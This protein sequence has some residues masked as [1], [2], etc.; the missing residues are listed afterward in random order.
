ME[1]LNRLEDVSCFDCTIFVF[2]AYVA[3]SDDHA[4][5]AEWAKDGEC[6]ENSRYMHESCKRSCKLCT[7]AFTTPGK[8]EAEQ[9]PADEPQRDLVVWCRRHEVRRRAREQQPRREA[10]RRDERRDAATRGET[11]R[12][13]ARRA[14]DEVRRR[15]GERETSRDESE[16]VGRA[17]ARRLPTRA[18][19][20]RRT[21]AVDAAHE[22]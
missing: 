5:C 14:D 8:H 21:E 11:P 2:P 17:E 15:D 22:R 9:Q 20:R 3:C 12:R 1:S 19:D 4:K 13:E 10:R 18:R 6:E 16:N 7:K